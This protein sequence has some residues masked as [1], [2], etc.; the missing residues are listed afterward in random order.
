MS[1]NNEILAAMAVLEL[2]WAH[3][4]QAEGGPTKDEI[5]KAKA[6]LQQEIV[7]LEYHGQ[8]AEIHGQEDLARPLHSTA[9]LLT[10]F[11]NHRG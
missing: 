3:S 7:N 5:V 1:T 2:D 6:F 11:L 8:N 10:E 4:M 9:C